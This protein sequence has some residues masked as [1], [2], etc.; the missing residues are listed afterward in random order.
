MKKLHLFILLIA[1]LVLGAIIGAIDNKP[2][3]QINVDELPSRF[4]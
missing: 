1:L 4:D 3:K 2:S